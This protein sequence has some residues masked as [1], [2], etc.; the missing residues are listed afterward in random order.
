MKTEMLMK[1]SQLLYESVNITVEWD[2][3]KKH[4]H[5]KTL[6]P[7]NSI[8][9]PWRKR[10]NIEAANCYRWL[11][12]MWDDDPYSLIV[13]KCD[14]I[15]PIYCILCNECS[16]SG[17]ENNQR[18]RMVICNTCKKFLLF[19]WSNC[20]THPS[21][22]AGC[23][24]SNDRDKIMMLLIAKWNCFVTSLLLIYNPHAEKLWIRAIP[25]AVGVQ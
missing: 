5:N 9:W 8:F 18:L 16:T 14:I 4:G 2:I 19:L 22:E 7:K 21:E 15:H 23:Y 17:W 13:C 25:I 1:C 3:P 20:N 6:V 11:V 10:V 24:Y 12:N